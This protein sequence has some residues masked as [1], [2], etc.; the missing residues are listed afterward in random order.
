MKIF[1]R[2]KVVLGLIVILVVAAVFGYKNKEYIQQLPI[3]S[4]F[5]TKALCAAVFVSGRDPVTTEREDIGFNPIFKIFK[6]KID[7]AEKSVTC[8]LLGLGLFEKK[9][10]YVDQMGC[11]LLSGVAEESIRARKPGIPRT[12]PANPET[13]L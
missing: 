1:N 5:K 11:V 4:A 3:G 8:S 10:I 7:R 6:A 2:K 12:E 9:A 13:I